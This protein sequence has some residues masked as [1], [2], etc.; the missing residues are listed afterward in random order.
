MRPCL[1]ILLFLLSL[2]ASA[3]S[4]LT[5]TPS[6]QPPYDPN[7]L[8]DNFF[9]GAGI[10]V[11]NVQFA[12]KPEAV[13]F[14][15]DG[16]A[17]VGIDRG[18]ILTTGRV[19]T[20]GTD[21]GAE[22]IGANFA[23]TNNASNVQS[24]PLQNVSSVPLYDVVYYKITFRPS[25]D[26]IRFRYVFASEEYPEYACSSFNDIFGFFL[27]GPKPGGEQYSD[28]NI[29]LVPN[30]NLPV[31]INNVHPFNDAYPD[32]P[33]F[34]IQYYINNNLS[35]NQPAYDGL[36]TPFIAE[37][38]V[39]PC[40]TY[41]MTIA[42]ADASDGVFDTGVF[43]EGN[44]F[45][46]AIDIQASF[47]PGENAIPENATGDTIDI[48][49]TDIP[50]SAL[51]L[52][53]TI[54]GEAENGID[55]L[56]IDPL[57]TISTADTLL[58]LVF[59]PVPDTLVEGLETILINVSGP[60]C[61]A[62]QFTVFLADP[63]SSMLQ[64]NIYE[65]A[66]V[67]G[68]A[69]LDA[70]PTSYSGQNRTFSNTN[71]FQ[72]DPV[73]ALISSP[74]AVNL[75]FSNLNTVKVIQSVCMNIEHSWDDDLKVFLIAPDERFVELTSNNGG[76][77]DNYT[78]TCFSPEATQ[79]IN[80]PGPF[81]PADAAPFTGEFQVEGEWSDILNAPVNGEWKLGLV[82]ENAGFVGGLIDWNITFSLSEVGNFKFLWSTGDTTQTIDVS[83]PGTYTVLV[84]NAV[85][86]FERTFIVSDEVNSVEEQNAAASSLQIWPNPARD[87]VN[88]SW[89]KNLKVQNIQ[90][91]DRFGRVVMDEN[92]PAAAA[93][94]TMRTAGLAAGTYFIALKTASG[95]IARKLTREK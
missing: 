81:A 48:A 37:A 41:E 67:G 8:I 21:F 55:F 43:L 26:S 80:F 47:N 45:G 11:L 36:T 83:T 35:N 50:A 6:D 82:D 25:S 54:G 18:L 42:L 94:H 19:A 40:E 85:S 86:H 91:I 59:Q 72:I 15:S 79:P 34:N 64:G 90:V 74:V 65:Y 70:I 24:Y 78:G 14:F 23:S 16:A 27:S 60:G 84:S 2:A 29:A 31:A 63:D 69:H 75:P 44:S 66:L 33:P 5:V 7:A 28:F 13:G 87:Q 68:T 57:Y 89:D 71:Y 51:P 95:T 52:T 61:L 22:E 62:R 93:S 3:Q 10:D 56:P 73:N 1:F 30:T 4:L 76:N 53:I 20:N 88:L 38:A 77:G 92:T 39:I 58:H 9:T 49:L 12:G 46:G 32:C 17:A